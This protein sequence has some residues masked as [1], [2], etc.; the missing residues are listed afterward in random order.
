MDFLSKSDFERKISAIFTLIFDGRIDMKFS[1]DELIPFSEARS[2]MSKVI[3]KV[4]A[5]REFVVTRHSKMTVAIISASQLFQFREMER[6]LSEYLDSIDDET[7]GGDVK[8]KLAALRRRMVTKQADFATYRNN[9][10]D[11][12]AV[13]ESD[14]AQELKNEQGTK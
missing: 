13:T 9:V 1:S 11:D 4:L 7:S 2:G 5:G 10:A 8:E 12:K 3:E 6:E 14:Q